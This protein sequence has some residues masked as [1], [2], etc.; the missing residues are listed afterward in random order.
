MTA[1]GA[2]SVAI[3]GLGFGRAHVPAFQ[4]AGARVIAV[5]QRDDAAAHK[6]VT[7]YGVPRV[8]RCAD[9]QRLKIP[10]SHCPS[11]PIAG[12]NNTPGMKRASV[13]GQPS[14]GAS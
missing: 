2:P 5:C 12:G 11:N 4:A 9:A 13:S 14:S 7:A 10:Y 3:I 8:G 6:V 1:A